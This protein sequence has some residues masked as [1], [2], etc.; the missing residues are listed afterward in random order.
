LNYYKNTKETLSNFGID[1]SPSGLM[2]LCSY[3]YLPIISYT[4]YTATPY[5][6]MATLGWSSAKYIAGPNY[7]KFFA[8][9]T[10]V[11]SVITGSSSIL[12]VLTSYFYWQFYYSL[13]DTMKKV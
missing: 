5:G 2:V 6:V 9:T 4:M 8:Y 13:P 7:S 11:L 10:P 1:L 3:L 12:S